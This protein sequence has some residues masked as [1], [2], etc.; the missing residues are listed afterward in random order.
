MSFPTDL[1]EPS[2]Q[3]ILV[4]GRGMVTDVQQQGPEPGYGKSAASSGD[5]QAGQSYFDHCDDEHRTD[6]Q[7]LLKR[8][9]SLLSFVISKRTGREK[10]WFVVVGVP[11]GGDAGAGA[12]LMHID[13]TPWIQER[14]GFNDGDSAP[15]WDMPVTLN[16]MLVQ[17]T[18]A[19]ALAK[20]FAQSIPEPKRGSI[21][22]A[23][24]STPVAHADVDSLSPRQRE[25][26][27]LVAAGKS[28]QEIAEDLDCSLNTVK[29]HVTAV[30]QKLRLPNRTR[31]A[32]LVNQLNL[33]P[34]DNRRSRR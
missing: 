16:P 33:L 27:L 6:V 32:A 23:A 30:L 5:Y 26:L 7:A 11:A 34:A 3:V 18:I 17:D 1:R 14:G 28:N 12:L 8:K 19:K 21:G 20:Q 15:G 10:N 22:F 29:R 4:D 13:I 9:R 2:V 24:K 31:A 25:V